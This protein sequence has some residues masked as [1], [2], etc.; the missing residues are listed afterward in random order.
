MQVRISPDPLSFS[1]LAGTLPSPFGLRPGRREKV[2]AFENAQIDTQDMGHRFH[3]VHP[4][5]KEVKVSFSSTIINVKVKRNLYEAKIY[6]ATPLNRQL[7]RRET[8]RQSPEL[9]ALNPGD[10][11]VPTQTPK[12]RGDRNCEVEHGNNDI[13]QTAQRKANWSL[14]RKP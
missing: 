6:K 8:S 4:I 3:H 7:A 9:R 2:L 11:L 1:S 14:T 13:S 12:V 10:Y 5:S